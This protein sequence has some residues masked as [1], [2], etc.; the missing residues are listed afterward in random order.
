MANVFEIFVKH[1]DVALKDMLKSLFMLH[2]DSRIADSNIAV[3][4]LFD[5][6]IDSDTAKSLFFDLLPLLGQQEQLELL[7]KIVDDWHSDSDNGAAD[8]IK[9]YIL[10]NRPI[11]LST[12]SEP[13]IQFIKSISKT[14]DVDLLELFLDSST[15]SLDTKF[16]QSWQKESPSLFSFLTHHQQLGQSSPKYLDA[17]F[18]K[19]VVLNEDNK[20]AIFFL[21]KSI[22]NARVVANHGISVYDVHDNDDIYNVF[23]S[24]P[25]YVVKVLQKALDEKFTEQ[26]SSFLSDLKA[27]SL[28]R[29]SVDI[30]KDVFYEPFHDGKLMSACLID[31]LTRE[32]KIYKANRVN[33][34]TTNL[35]TFLEKGVGKGWLWGKDKN[36]LFS[37]LRKLKKMDLGFA[38]KKIIQDL[39]LD[40]LIDS[41]RDERDVLTVSKLHDIEPYDM[42]SKVTDDKAKVVVL[43]AL[44]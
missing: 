10:K 21:F 4:A 39:S 25:N 8:L 14:E 5:S 37:S 16:S 15:Q 32:K 11:T 27:Y 35:V 34:S 31:I 18:K 23:T 38:Y 7:S 9:D 43:S 30:E 3:G 44:S 33:R 40:C 42:L 2:L 22:E 6:G 41:I 24:I 20:E 13:S 17:L 29:E 28:Q 26:S 19:G 1:S 12:K 36:K